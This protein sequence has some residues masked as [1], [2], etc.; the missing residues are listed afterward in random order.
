MK[1]TVSEGGTTVLTPGDFS[2]SHPQ[3]TDFYSVQ[4][5]VGGHFEVFNGSNWVSAPTGGFTDVQIA[6]GHVQFVQDGTATVPDFQIHVSDGSNASP[7]IAPNVTLDIPGANA[8]TI[9][10]AGPSGTLA[11][12][13]PS[14]FT[15]QIA[16]IVGSGDVLDL[17][18]F[19]AATTTAVSGSYDG[20]SNT[21]TLTVT[22]SSDNLI[23]TFKL[24]GDLSTSTWTVSDD[25]HGGANIVDPPGTANPAVGPVVAHDPGP[26]AP[27]VAHDP[28]PDA[29]NSII[30]GPWDQILKSKGFSDSFVF[31][32]AGFDHDTVTDFHPAAAALP[33]LGAMF[34]KAEGVLNAPHDDSHG[35]TV[36]GIGPDA[37]ITLES[38]LKAQLHNSDF[39][40][41]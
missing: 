39:H 18:G 13:N 5:V 21:T 19:A 8:Q 26:V 23:E 34:A 10:F 6:A 22:D 32:F 7:D 35:N 31:K 36:L 14:G 12:D 30:A 17:H 40:V 11:L 33:W 28:G 15:G 24:V 2:V 27:V 25:H 9:S 29:D 41:V 1:L 38:V 20:G 4:N 3:S 37:T 16:G